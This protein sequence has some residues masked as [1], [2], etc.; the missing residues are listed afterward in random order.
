MSLE[1]LRLLEN[2]SGSPCV[3]EETMASCQVCVETLAGT[4][5]TRGTRSRNVRG[6]AG[7][8]CCSER[9]HLL[10]GPPESPWLFPSQRRLASA[11]PSGQS[12]HT[13]SL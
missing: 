9:R 10:C 4:L 7:G 8:S 6:F 1:I 2:V 11:G 5:N 12:L 13:R 3:C